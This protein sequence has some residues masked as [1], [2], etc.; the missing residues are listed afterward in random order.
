MFQI[1]DE[2]V[3]LKWDVMYVVFVRL[4]GPGYFPQILYVCVLPDTED[5]RAHT[6]T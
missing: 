1:K 5:K 3:T 4:K 6:L 2:T